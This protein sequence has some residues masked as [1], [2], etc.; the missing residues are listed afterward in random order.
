MGDRLLSAVVAYEESG[1]Y[2]GQLWVKPPEVRIISLSP[3]ASFVPLEL[4]QFSAAALAASVP[5]QPCYV[6]QRPGAQGSPSLYFRSLFLTLF[7]VRL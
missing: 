5:A 3:S 1:W 2:D 6:Q 4:F 7:F